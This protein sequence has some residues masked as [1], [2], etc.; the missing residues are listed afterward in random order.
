MEGSDDLHFLMVDESLAEEHRS[1]DIKQPLAE[2]DETFQDEDESVHSLVLD[3]N[4]RVETPPVNGINGRKYD[5]DHVISF[6]LPRKVRFENISVESIQSS[7][8]NE[9]DP[10][11]THE[12]LRCELLHKFVHFERLC[13]SQKSS[14]PR[15]CFRIC[16]SSPT[17]RGICFS[18]IPH[19][20]RFKGVL[21]IKQ[22]LAELDETFQDEDESVHSLVLDENGRVETPSP[23]NGINGRKYDGHCPRPPAPI[24]K[25][26]NGTKQNHEDF[27]KLYAIIDFREKQVQQFEQDA[28]A[29]ATVLR[30]LNHQIGLMKTEM[31]QMKIHKD[32]LEKALLLQNKE[33][34]YL[35]A[36]MTEA[37]EELGPNSSPRAHS[38]LILSV[39]FQPPVFRSTRAFRRIRRNARR[40]FGRRPGQGVNV[41]STTKPSHTTTTRPPPPIVEPVPLPP[42]IPAEPVEPL[43]TKRQC[44]I[45]EKQIPRIVGRR[46]AD[47]KALPWMAALLRADG[48]GDA[49]NGQICGGVLISEFYVMTALHCVDGFEAKDLKRESTTL[50]ALTIL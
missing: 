33:I 29:Y 47:P 17:L 13:S 36:K 5:D 15:P 42:N 39:Q 27:D 1:D 24:D 28:K 26:N 7:K 40:A 14:H 21:Q 8:L 19:C 44:G 38:F 48:V 43:P 25:I 12:I 34:G 30:S 18:L 46:P 20:L 9:E 10:Q 22:A 11:S 16:Q 49:R 3:E 2:L 23:V 45:S 6:G 4:G 32:E 37:L 35:K 50:T 31:N 41:I